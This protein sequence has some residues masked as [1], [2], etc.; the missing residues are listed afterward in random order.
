M[1]LLREG[2]QVSE[3]AGPGRL[4]LNGPA[5]EALSRLTWQGWV[6]E[7]ILRVTELLRLFRAGVL[8]SLRRLFLV[9]FL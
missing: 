8:E 5:E 2:S 7:H 9:L 6:P 4:L 3:D 1:T